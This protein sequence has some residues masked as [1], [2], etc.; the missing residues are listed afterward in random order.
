V[1][2][3]SPGWACTIIGGVLE[4]ECNALFEGRAG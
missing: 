4:R 2:R 1:V 3:R